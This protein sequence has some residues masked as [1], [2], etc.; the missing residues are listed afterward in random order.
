MSMDDYYY[1]QQT[2][3]KCLSCNAS[4]DLIRKKAGWVI[5]CDDCN[6]STTNPTFKLW[7]V[8]VEWNQ[9]QRLSYDS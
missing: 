6:R 4:P 8:V 3:D 9:R 7:R 1:V 2:A 5:V